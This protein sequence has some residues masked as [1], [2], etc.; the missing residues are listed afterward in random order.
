MSPRSQSCADLIDHEPQQQR[1]LCHCVS[2][3]SLYDH[4]EDPSHDDN[5]TVTASKRIS[6]NNVSANATDSLHQHPLLQERQSQPQRRIQQIRVPVTTLLPI[7]VL[8]DMLAVS[9]VVPLLIQ[10]YKNA[11]VSSAAQR[12]LLSSVYSSSQIVGGL[13]FG[14]WAADAGRVQRRTMLIISYAGSLISYGMLVLPETTFATIV[15]S[16]ILVGLAKQSTTV[17]VSVLSAV[18]DKSTRSFHLGRLSSASTAAWI[19]G[20]S[21]G[22]LLH[23][24]VG[25]GAPCVVA[26]VL[27]GINIVLT[28]LFLNN[29]EMC[30]NEPTHAS[31]SSSSACT[32]NS[33][34]VQRQRRWSVWSNLQTCFSSRAL[35]SVVVASLLVTWVT[36][37]T[38]YS[39][40]GN[41]YEDMYG[42]EP[43]VRGYIYSYQQALQFLVQSLLVD[44]IL[45]VTGSERRTICAFAALLAVA[46]GLEAQRSRWLFF[47]AL[48]P[49]ISVSFAII[50]VT[51]QSL[52]THVAP[53]T[54]IFSVLAALDVLQNA[55]SVT[56]PF[57]RT[58]LF[59]WLPS[60]SEPAE[61]SSALLR[62]DPDPMAWVLSCAAHWI[63]ASLCISGLLLSNRYCTKTKGK[64][65]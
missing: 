52:V 4:G 40:L 64:R 58:A 18:T 3:E 24:Y 62:G 26:C 33:T 38:N 51:L 7:L 16:R 43:H 23:R 32:S 14:I 8:I 12:E 22:A 50:N 13:V 30:G 25:P 41:F 2:S 45:R 63:M 6:L 28:L 55:V 47:M 46:V 57:Y 11:G 21:I 49:L 42:L 44:R 10:Y 60:R 37:A 27:F 1:P 29:E 17:S 34:S 54:A 39:Q 31:S 56:V 48:C 9:L 15:A 61:S 5:A 59:Q 19:I 20:P 65:Q 53:P 36:R 35:G